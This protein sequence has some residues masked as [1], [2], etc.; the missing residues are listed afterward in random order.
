MALAQ[1]YRW[2]GPRGLIGLKCLL[3]ALAILCLYACLR[4]AA[5]IRAC[6]RRC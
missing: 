4:T 3:G 6:G 5:P 1:A 2:S